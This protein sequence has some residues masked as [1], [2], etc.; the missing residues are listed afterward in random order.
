MKVYPEDTQNLVDVPA[1]ELVIE[2]ISVQMTKID[3]IGRIGAVDPAPS[4]F[5]LSII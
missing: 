2:A 1:P 4:H 3:L 5:I